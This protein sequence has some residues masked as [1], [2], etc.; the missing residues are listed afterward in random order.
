MAS[1]AQAVRV[2]ELPARPRWQ[3]ATRIAFRF[4]FVYFGLYS[5]LTQVFGGITLLPGVAV[6][7]LGRV[8][9]IREFTFWSAQAI[10]G[11]TEPLV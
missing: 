1:K 9:P 2:Q 8:W 3:P 6:P 10:F 4:C 11:I 7:A 5:L